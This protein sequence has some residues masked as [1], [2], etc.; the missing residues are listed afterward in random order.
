MLYS[1]VELNRAAMA[2]M[3]LAARAG[4]MALHSPM[5]PIAQTQITAR[6]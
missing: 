6:R 2:P 1:L 3:R 4:R 5:N